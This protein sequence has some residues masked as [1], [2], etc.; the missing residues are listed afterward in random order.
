MAV[1]MIGMSVSDF[2]GLTPEEFGKITE[3]WHSIRKEQW[4]QV[5]TL[6]AFCIA[7]WNSK[8]KK[9]T[10][11]MPLPWD[12][13]VKEYPNKELSEEEKRRRFEEALKNR[14]LKN[15]NIGG[16]GQD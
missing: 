15:G 1:G 4:E 10:D 9:I 14:G 6:A 11:L 3:A 8:N 13:S 2:C 7:P 16:A 5:R 12:K